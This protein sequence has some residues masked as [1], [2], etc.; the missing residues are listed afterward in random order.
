MRRMRDNIRAMMEREVAQRR[1]AQTRL[2]DALESSPE[3]VVVIDAD[4]CLALANSQAADFLGISPDQLQ[5]GTPVTELGSLTA[6]TAEARL[7]PRGE[8]LLADGRW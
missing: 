2:A 3:G 8:A 7:S 5:P 6:Q 1:S 4:G